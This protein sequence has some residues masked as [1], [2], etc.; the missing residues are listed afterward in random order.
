MLKRFDS[1]RP[2]DNKFRHP[3]WRRDKEKYIQKFQIRYGVSHRFEKLE[4][5][6]AGAYDE[7]VGG[8]TFLRTYSKIFRSLASTGEIISFSRKIRTV[9]SCSLFNVSTFTR[10]LRDG[11]LEVYVA[12]NTSMF[13]HCLHIC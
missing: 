2:G 8:K 4:V 12:Y 7:L 13:P 1:G 5:V 3:Q 10:E 6:L 9:R 11:W